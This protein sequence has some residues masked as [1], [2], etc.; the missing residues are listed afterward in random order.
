[1]KE[2][3]SL[4]F[5]E[6]MKEAYSLIY[7]TATWCGPCKV[8]SPIV[9]EVSN[10]YEE[11]IKFGKIDAD[12]DSVVVE[13]LGVK[14]L[15]TIIIFKEGKEINRNSGLLSKQKLLTMIES[16]IDNFSNDEDF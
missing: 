6:I 3:N 9:S 4:Q 2:I 16:S 12:L 7:V 5:E 15:P 14:A 11:K 13:K 1:M 10:V 8:F